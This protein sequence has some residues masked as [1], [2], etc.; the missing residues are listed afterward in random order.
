MSEVGDKFSEQEQELRKR[1][2]GASGDDKLNLDDSSHS[3]PASL[4]PA[5]SENE[6]RLGS[7]SDHVR[8]IFIDF[9]CFAETFATNWIKLL[10]LLFIDL[11]N[12]HKFIYGENNVQ[13]KVFNHTM[14]RD[15]IITTQEILQIRLFNFFKS[16]SCFKGKSGLK[17]CASKVNNFAKVSSLSACKQK[18]QR[19][20]IKLCY[21]K[22]T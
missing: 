5:D 21:S 11:C 16:Y 22:K 6:Q 9:C 12:C 3:K 2:V 18:N 4:S 19:A 7:D 13:I 8:K 15:T 14:W 10:R 1:I 20:R 17:A